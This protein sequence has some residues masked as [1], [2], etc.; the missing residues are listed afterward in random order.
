MSRPLIIGHRGAPCVAPEHTEASYRAA[1]AAGV[2]LVEPDVVVS[3]DGILVV[4]HEPELGST[5]DVAERFEYGGRHT[6][7]R[8]GRIAETGWF[9]EDFTLAELRTLSARE[10]LPQLRRDSAV[11]GEHARGT[12]LTQILSLTDL[13]TLTRQTAPRVGLVIEL[14]HDGRTRRLGYDFAELLAEQLDGLWDASPLRDVR[15]ECFEYGL[16]ERMREK[17]L[18]G[19]RIL[20]IAPAVAEHD[21]AG[22]GWLSD[23]AL[24]RVAAHHH[25]ISVHV[26]QLSRGLVQ[27][28]HQ[29]GLEIFSY[30]VR[31]EPQFLPPAFGGNAADYLHY[32]AETG[33]DALFCDDPAGAITALGA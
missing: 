10:R 3:K 24:D 26:S 21:E 33:V 29:R 4:R 1:F 6:C 19:K 14:K 16:L 17:N 18:P 30:T 9:A 28:A 31:P 25:G 13:V 23:A 7:K 12:R 5:T 20:L 2:D 27:R 22:P 8:A 15:W 32:L 11:V